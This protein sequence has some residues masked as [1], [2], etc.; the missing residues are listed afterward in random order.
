[1]NKRLI[2]LIN[3]KNDWINKFYRELKISKLIKKILIVQYHLCLKSYKLNKI[4]TIFSKQ[5]Q[6]HQL[7]KYNLK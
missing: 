5:V 2:S 1:M 6:G 4:K 7:I 3:C